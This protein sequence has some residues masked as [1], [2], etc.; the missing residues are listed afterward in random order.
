MITDTLGLVWGVVVHA[1]NQADGAT[2][3]R[4][5]APLGGYL[6]RMQKIL[7]DAAYEKI[8]VDWVTDN[9]LGEEQEITAKPPYA[10]GF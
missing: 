9:L 3:G 7:F 10:E 1:A 4:M 8:F 6:H 2:A 5:V